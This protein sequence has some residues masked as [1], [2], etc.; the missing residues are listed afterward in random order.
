MS[1]RMMQ[2]MDMAYHDLDRIHRYCN[3]KSN[4]AI[5]GYGLP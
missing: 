5:Y 2:S 3:E 4:D 1:N